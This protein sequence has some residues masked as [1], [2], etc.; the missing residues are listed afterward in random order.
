[1]R[2]PPFSTVAVTVTVL[3]VVTGCAALDAVLP[4]TCPVTVVNHL[5]PLEGG[6]EPE[7]VVLEPPYVAEMGWRYNND[8]QLA[9]VRI[10]GEDWGEAAVHYE[11]MDPNGEVVTGNVLSDDFRGGL[12]GIS[13][14]TAGT[15]RYHLRALDD[16]VECEQTVTIEVLPDSKRRW[17]D[18]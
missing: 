18:P 12:W 10:G 13:F 8:R 9:D 3:L 17:T 6:E 16:Q 14:S 15:W 7:E 2:R 4:V 11:L 1:M 5:M